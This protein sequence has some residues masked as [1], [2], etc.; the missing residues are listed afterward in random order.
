MVGTDFKS[1]KFTHTHTYIYTHTHFFIR[2]SSLLMITSFSLEHYALFS[3][4]GTLAYMTKNL[5]NLIFFSVFDLF[6]YT[7]NYNISYL[8]QIRVMITD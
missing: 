3:S 4:R 5:G 6:N 1:F 2:V 7:T 8:W